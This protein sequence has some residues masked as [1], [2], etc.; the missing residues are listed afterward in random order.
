MIE[1]ADQVKPDRAGGVPS[2]GVIVGSAV[3]DGVEAVASCALRVAGEEA[4]PLRATRNS[5]LATLF[6]WQLKDVHRLARPLRPKGHPQPVR[7]NP[8]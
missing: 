2:T 7:F 5:Q 1:L 3:I 6:K 8:F 4:D